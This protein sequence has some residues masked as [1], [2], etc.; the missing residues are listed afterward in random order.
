M[1]K[2]AFLFLTIAGIHHES[3][4]QDFFRNHEDAYSIYVHSK[5]GVPTGS[6]FKPYEMRHTKIT[7]WSN[8][9]KA[10]IALLAHALED[11]DNTVFIFASET[12]IPLQDFDYVYKEHMRS[13]NKSMFYFRPNTHANR[14]VHGYYPQQH[15]NL[16]PIP[17]GKQYKNSQWIVLN[18]KHA[19]MMVDDQ[20]IIEIAT[21]Y[22][23]DQEHYPST[24]LALKGVL[25]EEVEPIDT[26][27]VVWD[28]NPHPPYV[29]TN[30]H[31]QQDMEL[32][33]EAISQGFSFI[34]KV[35]P[36]CD[37]QPLDPY[38]SYRTQR[39]QSKKRIDPALNDI[40]DTLTLAPTTR[41]RRIK[42]TDD[43]IRLQE[44]TPIEFMTA[45]EAYQQIVCDTQTRS[46]AKNAEYDPEFVDTAVA[47]AQLKKVHI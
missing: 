42:T 15:R 47:L 46:R 32:L 39:T 12:T 45:D 24:F 3:Y 2:I 8:T 30:L 16:Q 17:T 27:Q 28:K 22:G 7:T 9:M 37:L 10:Q 34:R 11:P 31:N 44:K 1:L 20:D 19:Q 25:F 6:F 43:D 14:S 4:W 18:R 23:S 5:N 41:S 36:A 40:E 38:L 21:Q 29:F 26:T 35:D 33:Q 13:D